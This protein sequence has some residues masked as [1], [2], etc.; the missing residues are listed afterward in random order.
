MT[1]VSVDY[2]PNGTYSTYDDGVM[3]AYKMT[4]TFK[5]LEAVYNDDYEEGRS[6]N[7]GLPAEIGF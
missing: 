2:T 6:I 5:E 7:S 1:N 4:L 3:T